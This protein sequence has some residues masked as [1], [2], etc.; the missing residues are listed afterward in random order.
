[1]IQSLLGGAAVRW[2]IGLSMV[3]PLLAL[4]ILGV[5]AYRVNQ[6]VVDAAESA[7]NEHIRLSILTIKL[8]REVIQTQQWLTDISATRGLDGLG[9]GFDEARKAR[10]SFMAHLAEAERIIS[11]SSHERGKLEEIGII[12]GRFTAYYDL[13][14][15]MAQAYIDE[16]PQAGNP[17]M[18]KFDKE[19]EE[20]SG[21]LTP[22][23]KAYQD[24]A[25][26]S[27]DEITNR[28]GRFQS[29]LPFVTFLLMAV[30]AVLAVYVSRS[31]T[32]PLLSTVNVIGKI[33]GGDFTRE[34]EV[35][36]R[37]EIGE[38]G[39]AINS[40]VGNLKGM[41]QSI[42]E[43]S[44]A[45][46]TSSTRLSEVSGKLAS[47]SEQMTVQAENV[48]QAAERMS[49]NI[50]TMASAVEEMSVIVTSVSDGAEKMTE[51]M[52]TASS[53]I[54]E[55]TV[56]INSIAKSA[57]EASGVSNKAM[58][59]SAKASSTMDNLGLAAREIGKVTE[60][61]KRIAEQTNLLALN[62]TIEAASAGA[63]GKGFAVV[64]N[65]IKELASQSGAAAGDIANRISGIQDNSREAVKVIADV[66][67]IIKRINHSVETIT[68]SVEQQ[69]GAVSSISETVSSAAGGVKHV[70]TSMSEVSKGA[71]EVSRNTG[72][73]ANAASSV[74]LNIQ[75]VSAAANEARQSAGDIQESSLE[76]SRI[77]GAMEE[78]VKKFNLSRRGVE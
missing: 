49:Q 21:V 7:K 68:E 73:A 36:T 12:R 3:I 46:S 43:G 37:D 59:M 63:A 28:A 65:E 20:L 41:I 23:M 66:A 50:N 54:E 45:L 74:T 5:W 61:I 67:S 13:G 58:E 53:S 8:E 25:T 60:V 9:D 47:G 22:F 52:I 38:L 75:G 14:R 33:A 19:A 71:L 57:R 62:A 4:M 17:I 31:L 24:N 32:V 15:K 78:M 29:S 51:G 56:S 30:S 69:A 27:M 42:G 18:R 34:V 40:M 76:I 35:S 72:E 64:A 70:A 2:K 55:L 1:M 10:D 48:S 44:G 26:S 39:K 16:G 77:A 6:E 11:Q